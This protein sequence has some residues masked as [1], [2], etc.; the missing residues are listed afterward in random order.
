LGKNID[1]KKI[2]K[3]I[4]LAEKL[5]NEGKFAELEDKLG[6]TYSSVVHP[7]NNLSRNSRFL[8]SHNSKSTLVKTQKMSIKVTPQAKEVKQ[9]TPQQTQSPKPGSKASKENFSV[10]TVSPKNEEIDL[11]SGQKFGFKKKTKLIIE[12]ITYN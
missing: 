5:I 7:L 1:P 10:L 9:V 6:V 3:G 2:K 12:S 8:T 4:A 11:S